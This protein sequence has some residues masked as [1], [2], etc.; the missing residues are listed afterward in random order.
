MYSPTD[1]PNWLLSMPRFIKRGMVFTLI[2][3]FLP[4][5]QYG[6]GPGRVIALDPTDR[7]QEIHAPVTGV[8]QQ[9]HVAEGQEVSAGQLLVTLNDTDQ[10]LLPRLE[11]EQEV[12]RRSFEAAENALRTGR[13]NLQR[14]ERLFTDGLSPRK[15]WEDEQI[16]VNT[17]E[18]K[19]A[20][21][22]TKLLKSQNTLARQ[23]AQE[24]RAPRAGQLLRLRS[25]QGGQLIKQGDVLLVL[26][27]K[28]ASL[29]IELWLDGNDV[30]LA[31]VG[32]HGRVEFAGWPAVQIPGWPAMAVGTFRAKVVA[33]DTVT[34]QN[35][36][37]RVLLSPAERWPTAP[38]LRQG[39]PV[40]GFVSF[41]RVTVAQ[42]L[43][44][45]FN[46]LPLSGAFQENPLG[47]G[48]QSEKK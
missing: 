7:F 23:S 38:Y 26:S 9:W 16:K 39:G 5:Q 32:D 35:G 8:I 17:L 1:I 28:D 4:W 13:L 31:R 46:G 47:H 19:L 40:E 3:L 11:S 21:A 25:G 27:P 44:R 18:I 42:E 6:S 12:T 34:A 29:G 45:R 30:A 43:W 22:R 33:V 14:Q 15:A 48:E 36:R 2:L 41:R 10:G 37:F 20:E 24:V